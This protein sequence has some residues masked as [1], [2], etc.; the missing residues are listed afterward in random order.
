MADL[1]YI[2]EAQEV[3]ITGQDAT[4]NT[5]NFVSADSNGNISSKDFADGIPGAT[6]PSVALQVGGTDGV[7]LRALSTDATGKLN[8][9]NISGT[10]S[11]PTGAATSALQTTGNTSLASI[12]TNTNA[13]ILAQ[14]SATSGQTGNL[15][16]GAV[17]TASPI[18][19]TAQ[20]S[21][22]SLTTAGALRVD[23][24]AVTQPVSGTVAVTQSTSP[25][26]TSRNWTLTSGTD[27]VASVQSGIWTVQPGNTANT[28]PWLVTDSSD[29]PV[30][31]GVVA[32]KSSLSGGQFNTS[33]PVLTTG[34][35][36]ALQVDS[37]GRLITSPTTIGGTVAVTQSTSPWVTS[38][39]ATN[40]S[41]TA[42]AIRGMQAMGVFNT[43]PTTL[44]NGQSG[45]LQ[46]DSAENLLVNLKTAI[47]T[48]ANTI[49]AVTQAS[50]PW[51]QNLTQVGG[52]A[53]TLGQKTMAN[54]YP[55]TL[56]SDQSGINTFLDKSGTGTIAALNGSVTAT[57]NGCGTVTFNITGV[58]VATL[59]IQGTNDNST[60]QAINSVQESNNQI[61]SFTSSNTMITVGCGGFSQVRLTAV[62]FTSGTATVT[63]DAGAGNGNVQIVTPVNNVDTV[64]NGGITALNGTSAIKTNGASS[65]VI[66]VTN[67]FVATLQLAALTAD[68]ISH[69]IYGFNQTTGQMVTSITVPAVLVV[70]CGGYN[71]VYLTAT[72][73]TSGTASVALG[74]SVGHNLSYAI[75]SPVDSYKAS[76][77][78]AF[79]GA[80]TAA[81]AT[82]VFT[83]TGSVTKTIRVT[84]VEVSAT[85]TTAAYQ[86][87]LLVRRS[88]ANT[89]G[90]SAAV[91]ATTSDS[92][93]PAATATLL[94]YTANPTTGTLVGN[95]RAAKQ[96]VPAALTVA[97]NPILA[98]DFG[99]RPAQAEVLR[100]T[101]QVIAINLNGAGVTGNSFNISVEWTEE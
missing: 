24:S 41:A 23:S 85:Q 13:L 66:N 22:L 84:R 67:V 73:F 45:F 25:W 76:Y 74:A 69:N 6:A 71:S 61:T 36:V 4:G 49:G 10:V 72:A 29:G 88:T 86:T 8:L 96:F 9:N 15:V 53:I 54:S 87:I 83:I 58:W 63:W 50:G 98:W 46:L 42:A 32:I 97:G 68:G 60:W 1:P 30:T 48:G 99:N 28:T 27:S 62:A 82:D 11:L 31:A 78:A 39:T 81:A 77:S 16:M 95:I 100:G 35:Q 101:S 91:T 47:P 75:T 20:T 79:N 52:S 92:N 51:T 56:A 94:S 89:V 90:T 26:V 44:T 80:V 70:P 18:Y 43:T 19:T 14:G 57:T 38:D 5:V 65:V 37:S 3:K 40:T 33:L 59:G 7:N 93:N 2:Q 17:T 12:V 55:V 21:P 64:I 34:Q